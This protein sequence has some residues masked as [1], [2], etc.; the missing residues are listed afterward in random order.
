MAC[1]YSQSEGRTEVD[2]HLDVGIRPSTEHVPG[3][4]ALREV[5]DGKQDCNPCP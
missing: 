3:M 1:G 5:N 2:E 4:W